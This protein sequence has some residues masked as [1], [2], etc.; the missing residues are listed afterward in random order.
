MLDFEP[1]GFTRQA[2]YR[3]IS[4]FAGELNDFWR[5]LAVLR[6]RAEVNL[7]FL[8]KWYRAKR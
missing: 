5:G 4:A 2:S 3:K 7:L 6:P 1:V 8:P